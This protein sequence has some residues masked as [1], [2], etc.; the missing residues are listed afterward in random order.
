MSDERRWNDHDLGGAKIKR[1]DRLAIAAGRVRLQV[2][3]NDLHNPISQRAERGE[4][5]HVETCQ[6]LRQSRLIALGIGP[7]C[8]V[9]G[10]PFAN[11]VVLLQ[12]AEGMLEDGFLRAGAKR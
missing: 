1:L 12:G 10:K 5:A 7:V 8:E 3:F 9:V 6:S 4:P 2:I 11:K